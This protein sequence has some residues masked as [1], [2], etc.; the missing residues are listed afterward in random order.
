MTRSGRDTSG[1]AT[2]MRSSSRASANARAV[3]SSVMLPTSRFAP[4]STATQQQPTDWWSMRQ[5][6]P[7]HRRGR[8]RSL[9]QVTQSSQN[10][11]NANGTN[12][13]AVTNSLTKMMSSIALNANVHQARIN[14]NLSTFCAQLFKEVH[15]DYKHIRQYLKNVCARVSEDNI[16]INQAKLKELKGKAED[17]IKGNFSVI[18]GKEVDLLLQQ[19]SMMVTDSDYPLID[20]NNFKVKTIGRDGVGEGVGRAF[21]TTCQEKLA[22]DL[23]EE[24]L[25][26]AKIY[27][28]KK[29]L[30]LKNEVTLQ[31]LRAYGFILGTMFVNGLALPFNLRRILLHMCLKFHADKS[32]QHETLKY[33]IVY[34]IMEDPDS[35][36]SLVNLMRNP[37]AIDSACLDFEYINLNSQ[38]VNRGNFCSF[39]DNKIMYDNSL[40]ACLEVAKGFPKEIYKNGFT[41]EQVFKTICKAEI[42]RQEVEEWVNNIGFGESVPQDF[43]NEFKKIL[44]EGDQSFLRKVLEFWGA[45]PSILPGKHYELIMDQRT[46]KGY[47]VVDRKEICPLPEA[48]TCYTQL[49]FPQNMPPSKIKEKMLVALGEVEEGLTM[50]GGQRRRRKTKR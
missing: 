17:G 8:E 34:Q 35:V 26:E 33:A 50:K 47:R 2:A 15:Q 20:I 13:A 30:D 37:E 18:P 14:A 24:V 36:E 45:A 22:E 3:E 5:P 16:P 29:D 10:A 25:P 1:T 7:L 32:T 48:H 46:G 42:P 21:F 28:F 40:Y 31:K 9:T 39:F 38:Q 11:R 12:T 41:V 44:V 49:V 23:L 6:E 19:L 27:H 43:K 4:S